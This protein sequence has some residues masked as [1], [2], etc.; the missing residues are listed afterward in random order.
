MNI[1]RVEVGQFRMLHNQSF[2]LGS[3]LTAILGQNGTMKTTLL[4]M[5]GEPFRFEAKNPDGESYK[6]IGNGLFQLKFSDA[7]KFSDGPN[8]LERAGDHRWNVYIDPSIYPEE[9]YRARTIPRTNIE[10]NDIRTWS[11]ETKTKGSKHIQFPCIYLSLKRLVPIGEERNID[12]QPI[13]LAEKE[14]KWFEK[15]HKRILLIG[16]EMKEAELVHSR[17]KNTLGFATNRYDSLTN[18]AGQDNIGKILL[19]ILSFK[20]LKENLGKDYKGGLLLIDEVDA[21]LYPAA[22]KK[23]IEFLLKETESLNLQ[24]VFTTHSPDTIKVLFDEKYSSQCKVIYL[25]TRDGETDIYE[26]L[27]LPRILAH[28]RAEVASEHDIKIKV[29]AEDDSTRMFLKK[30]I[31]PELRGKLDYV[32]ISIGHGELNKL[33]KS[34]FAEI[35]NSIFVFDGDVNTETKSY[36]AENV[37]ALPG[38]DAPEV[39]LFKF[40][41]SL[42][43]RD[44]FWSDLPGGYS[45]QICLEGFESFDGKSVDEAKKWFAREKKY[46]GPGCSKLLNRWKESNKDLVEKFQNKLV[47]AFLS[48]GGTL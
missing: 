43:E 31:P 5:V 45:K 25:E 33:R 39:V 22:Q 7:F 12:H 10:K 16:D 29:L 9:V 20:R 17:N 1:R 38:G 2:E 44:K 3:K 26:N 24:V 42:P 40:V 41:D 36:K 8:G 32:N 18:S 35:K 28:L 14:S 4:G 23:L 6:V 15:Y 21:T 46:F 37:L 11:G 34:G 13:E 48:V 19:S 27:P 47:S 30:L